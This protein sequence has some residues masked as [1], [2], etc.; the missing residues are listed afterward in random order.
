[1][2][3]FINEFLSYGLLVIIFAAIMI[4]GGFIGVKLRGA[5]D[6]KAKAA[7]PEEE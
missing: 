1:M 2:V 4:V 6:A 7:E 3:A 5:K